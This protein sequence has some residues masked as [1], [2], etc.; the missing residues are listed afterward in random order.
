MQ[1]SSTSNSGSTNTSSSAGSDIAKLQR[2]LRDLTE[3]L[4]NVVTSNL[5]AKA[6]AEKAKLLQAQIQMVQAQI[7][8]IQR[9]NQ[10]KQQDAQTEKVKATDRVSR[11]QKAESNGL[12]T[13][14]G[15]NVDTHA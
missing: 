12:L 4:K 7:A 15:D 11:K 3:E 1:V 2:Q 10:Q 9:A 13:G 8:A 5:D 14:F 6:K